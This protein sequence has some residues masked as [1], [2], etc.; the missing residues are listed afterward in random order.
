MTTRRRVE[1]RAGP[2]LSG[3]RWISVPVHRTTTKPCSS[4]RS[5][6]A[7]EVRSHPST[8]FA[9]DPLVAPGSGNC[10]STNTAKD[11]DSFGDSRRPDALWATSRTSTAPFHPFIDAAMRSSSATVAVPRASVASANTRAGAKPWTR[12]TS[13]DVRA[14]LRMGMPLSVWMS[15]GST[16]TVRRTRPGR[17][18]RPFERFA[19][20]SRQ[21]AARAEPVARAARRP[22]S[23]SPNRAGREPATRPGS[24]APAWPWAK[25]HCA[26]TAVRHRTD[27]AGAAR[28]VRSARRV[29]RPLR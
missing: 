18:W 25:L 22:S 17:R 6:R 19:C 1:E 2:T 10:L 26:A 28:S 8:T 21:T 14:G 20:E 11:H 5:C 13:N 7:F 3:R 27:H 29:A 24:P 12:A 23:D 9:D 16:V 15:T 4:I